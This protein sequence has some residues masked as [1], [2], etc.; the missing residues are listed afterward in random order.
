M[1]DCAC[2]HAMT[3][4]FQFM[5]ILH[6]DNFPPNITA[7]DMF[8]V[9]IGQMNIFNFTVQDI[10]DSI[11]VNVV[12]KISP[13]ELAIVSNGGSQYS[14]LYHPAAV[15]NETLTLIATDPHNASATFSPSL[16]FCACSN[17]GNCTLEGLVLSDAQ[18]LTMNCA[19]S[20]GTLYMA[21][22]ILSNYM[23]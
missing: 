18:T 21:N 17:G 7:E 14:L 2:K 5:S 1:S 22:N 20:E 6:V 12:G 3:S 10:D 15:S 16:H 4:T 19:C 9:K 13:T 8:N 23:N 11:I